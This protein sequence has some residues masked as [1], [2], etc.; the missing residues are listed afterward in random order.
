M[1]TILSFS[2]INYNNIGSATM[3]GPIPPNEPQNNPPDTPI[4]QSPANR[5]RNI[6]INTALS[7]EC[8][9]PDGDPLTY[10]IY[11]GMES[12]PN[13]IETDYTGTS[14]TPGPLECES[15]Y[16]WK[17]VARDDKGEI[18]EGETWCFKTIEPTQNTPPNKPS[19]PS[20]IDKAEDGNIENIILSWN[21]ND[22][23]GDQCSYDVYWG[24][25]DLIKI[26]SSK[27]TSSTH[28]IDNTIDYETTYYWQIIAYDNN[29]GITSGPIWSLTTKSNPIVEL[30][31]PV[32]DPSAGEPYI[33]NIN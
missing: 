6:D 31:P 3:V 25:K 7:W 16:Y 9:D 29:G 21:C 27:I 18:T 1:T 12:S 22:P 28:T 30:Q 26:T 23:D 8:S 11:F 33:A 2:I 20:P 5:A 17:I 32:A 14:Y 19:N 13:V 24:L 4:Y 15:T 10:D